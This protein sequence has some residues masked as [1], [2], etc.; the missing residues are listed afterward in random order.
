MAPHFNHRQKYT[1][2]PSQNSFA[3]NESL[4]HLTMALLLIKILLFFFSTTV[5]FTCSKVINVF[6]RYN[7][8]T[9]L[10]WKSSKFNLS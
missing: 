6:K 7:S 5:V 10:F 2:C 1:A 4:Q 9:D 3:Y 8:W